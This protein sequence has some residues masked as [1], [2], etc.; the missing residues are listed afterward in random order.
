MN[1]GV[2][3]AAFTTSTNYRHPDVSRLT[4][5][6]GLGGPDDGF[7]LSFGVLLMSC[8]VAEL[9]HSPPSRVLASGANAADA[10]GV[11]VGVDDKALAASTVDGIWRMRGPFNR[12]L[13]ALTTTRVVAAAVWRDIA[14]GRFNRIMFQ[15][16]Y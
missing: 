1:L 7:N 3:V 14:S 16:R 2:F 8:P 12:A 5:V 10:R 15:R 4:S 9:E 13:R 6:D 11:D